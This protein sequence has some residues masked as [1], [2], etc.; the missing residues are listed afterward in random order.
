MTLA[1]TVQAKK[2]P[3]SEAPPS[4]WSTPGLAKPTC[5]TWP[6]PG[7]L[8]F[9]TGQPCPA[10]PHES[11]TEPQVGLT[12][13]SRIDRAEAALRDLGF[14]DVRVRHYGDTARIEVPAADI[15]ALAEQSA[16][17]NKAVCSVGYRYVTIDLAGLQ[18]GNLNLALSQ[19]TR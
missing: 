15:V 3:K 8:R 10:W 19:T 7:I 13:L 11:P 9:G 18:S 1:T 14:V 17:I 12:L 4:L 6:R 16:A 2:Q 5:D